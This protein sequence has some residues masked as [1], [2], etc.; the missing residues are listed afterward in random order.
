MYSGTFFKQQTPATPIPCSLLR[1]D[2]F[3]QPGAEQRVKGLFLLYDGIRQGTVFGEYL[4]Q[5]MTPALAEA[6]AKISGDYNPRHV[7][8][9]PYPAPFVEEAIAHGVYASTEGLEAFRRHI[10]ITGNHLSLDRIE[11]EFRGPVFLRGFRLRHVMRTGETPDVYYVDTFAE[12]NTA[13]DKRPVVVMKIYLKPGLWNHD[14]FGYHLYSQWLVSSALAITWEGCLFYKYSF[15][16]VEPDLKEGS[17]LVTIHGQKEYMDSRDR[18]HVLVDF[19]I[20]GSAKGTADI[21]P[22]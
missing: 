19:I 6:A 7:G 11:I 17:S 15:D 2:A 21:I 16:F 1:H 13:N 4:G 18:K 12:K 5:P 8:K 22:A 10:V 3:R 14:T 9:P 20:F